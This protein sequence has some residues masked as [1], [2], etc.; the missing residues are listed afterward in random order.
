MIDN[1]LNSSVGALFS[2]P[3]IDEAR[4]FFAEK[5]HDLTN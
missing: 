4:R 3:D 2:P 1:K 5:S